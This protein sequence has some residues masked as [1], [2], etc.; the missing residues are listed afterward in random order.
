MDVLNDQNN[1]MVKAIPVFMWLK[2][3]RMKSGNLM[4]TLQP[5][6]DGTIASR[7]TKDFL[8]K[9]QIEE[10]GVQKT[11]ADIKNYDA[12]SCRNAVASLAH[13][14]GIPLAD[15]A[16]HVNTSNDSLFNTY[17]C[18]IDDPSEYPHDCIKKTPYIAAK[19]LVPTVHFITS[20]DGE[21]CD[22][23][24]LLNMEGVAPL[25]DPFNSS[26]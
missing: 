7:F 16:A 24:K 13:A 21:G 10:G 25:T 14:I 15:I 19:L 22:C 5:M 1:Q 20:K 11:F 2:K 6:R 12:H 8:K 18:S 23:A 26:T 9:Q 4:Q 3:V 17:I